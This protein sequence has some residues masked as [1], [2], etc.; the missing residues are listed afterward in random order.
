MASAYGQAPELQVEPVGLDTDGD[1]QAVN[2]SGYLFYEDD[3][4]SKTRLTATTTLTRIFLAIIGFALV[5]AGVLYGVLGLW[6][7]DRGSPDAWI[8]ALLG[9]LGA[10]IG[11]GLLLWAGRRQRRAG[12]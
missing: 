6:G 11:A 8:L 1:V 12:P 9:L 10:A 7:A 5:A 3:C 2:R 4:S